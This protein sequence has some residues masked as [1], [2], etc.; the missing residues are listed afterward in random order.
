MAAMV[1]GQSLGRASRDQAT[2]P[3]FCLNSGVF[4]WWS[5]GHEGFENFIERSCNFYF[6][7]P[8]LELILDLRPP[9]NAS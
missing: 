6:T 8:I 1:N 3:W 5:H 4:N 2:L 9:I 7:D